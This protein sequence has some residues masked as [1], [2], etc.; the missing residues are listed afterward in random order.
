[1]LRAGARDTELPPPPGDL[2]DGLINGLPDEFTEGTTHRARVRSWKR[3]LV[4]AA[5]V[6]GVTM[7]GI[8]TYEL[9]SGQSFS[10][11]E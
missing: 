7:G 10:G 6:F 9:A 4:A 8:T 5:V 3:P 2:G 11:D 1:M